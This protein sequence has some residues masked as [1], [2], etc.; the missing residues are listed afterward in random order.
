MNLR[1][2]VGVENKKNENSLS[3]SLLFCESLVSIKEILIEKEKQ[4]ERQKENNTNR[5]QTKLNASHARYNV[6]MLLQ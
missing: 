3:P 2:R 4:E 6:K 5:T 1:E